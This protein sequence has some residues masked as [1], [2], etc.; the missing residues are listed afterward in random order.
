MTDAA[1]DKP[2]SAGASPGSS[3]ALTL[4]ELYRAYG[5]RVLNLAFRLTGNEETARDL[6]QDIWLKVHQ[7]LGSFKARSHVFTW[8]YRIALNHIVNHIKREK[9]VRWLALLER[10]VGE[11]V[12]EEAVDPS[13]RDRAR[14]VRP[15]HLVEADERASAVWEAVHELD[16][17]YRVPL[18]LHHYEQLS[19]QEI[20]ETM[21]LS[22]PAVEARIHRAKKQLI[23]KL[24]SRLSEL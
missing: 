3:G 13:V 20:A 5:V 21:D 17:K 7:G 22:L 12:H 18:V 11:L 6:A 15:D 19:Y 10:T 9:R 24:G 23:K 4:D 14:S 8:I 2:L 1:N 16:A